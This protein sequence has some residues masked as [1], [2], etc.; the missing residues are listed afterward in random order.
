MDFKRGDGE[1]VSATNNLDPQTVEPVTDVV[2]ESDK[3]ITN[4]ESKNHYILNWP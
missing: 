4:K 3:Q 2:R 1:L